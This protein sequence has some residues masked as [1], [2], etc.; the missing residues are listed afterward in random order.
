MK[1]SNNMENLCKPK[2]EE[3]HYSYDRP[4]EQN[5]RND[6]PRSEVRN[7]ECRKRGMGGLFKKSGDEPGLPEILVSANKLIV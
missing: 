2:I 7:T 1:N 6:T 3:K 5:I 4:I